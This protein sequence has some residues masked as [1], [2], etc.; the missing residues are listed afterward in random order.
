MCHLASS[1]LFD[2]VSVCLLNESAYT[3]YSTHSDNKQDTC[4]AFP[5][6]HILH[7][8]KYDLNKSPAC[9]AS[10]SSSGSIKFC[11]VLY[12]ILTL[13]LL[14][15]ICLILVIVSRLSKYFLCI[16]HAVTTMSIIFKVA[17]IQKL[18]FFHVIY[19][20]IVCW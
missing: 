3:L 1:N 13:Y 11:S 18:N 2:V 5:L 10:K 20:L 14:L 7:W 17:I 9:K 19:L 4:R 8:G 6:C 12:T 15:N 16:D